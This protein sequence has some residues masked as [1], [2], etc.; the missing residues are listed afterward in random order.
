LPEPCSYGKSGKKEKKKDLG[1]RQ[2]KKRGT[3][4]KREKKGPALIV[5]KFKPNEKK[6]QKRKARGIP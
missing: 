5:C 2:K 6:G 3:L 1:R 4:K